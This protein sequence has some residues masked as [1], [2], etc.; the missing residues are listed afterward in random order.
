MSR[1][2]PSAPQ[3]LLPADG[4]QRAAVSVRLGK[5]Q[6]LQASVEV[7]PAGLLAIGGLVSAI[8]LSTAVL[9]RSATPRD[10]KSR[11]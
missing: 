3:A 4:R 1:E 10:R 9:V 8:L 11:S 2:V 5:R 6:R 7:T